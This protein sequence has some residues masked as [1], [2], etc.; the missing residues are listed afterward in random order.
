M[1]WQDEMTELLKTMTFDFNTP[2]RYPD[3]TYERLLVGAAK[4]V[5]GELQFTQAFRADLANTDIKP[6]PT[7]TTGGTRDDNFVNL[8]CMK[9]AAI[10]DQGQVRLE[11]GIIIRD[12]GSMVDLHYKLD[13]AIKLLNSSGGWGNQYE[14]Q[15]LLYLADQLDEVAG[16]A[17][18]GPFRSVAGE[19]YGWDDPE[20]RM[21]R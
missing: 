15:K 4:L 20:P 16:R 5:S 1:A 9:A 18:M 7:D 6:D 14:Q 19:L 3:S 11:S 13:A 12:N 21:Y 8:V 17:V 10:I 2:A